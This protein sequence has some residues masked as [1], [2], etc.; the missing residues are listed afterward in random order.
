MTS[1][2]STVEKGV[3]RR[4]PPPLNRMGLFEPYIK[5]GKKITEIVRYLIH[6]IDIPMK[7]LYFLDLPRHTSH[8]SETLLLSLYVPNVVETN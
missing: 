1:P 4:L 2:A 7:T 8:T 3:R 6:S 5:D